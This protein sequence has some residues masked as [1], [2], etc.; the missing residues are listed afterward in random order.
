MSNKRREWLNRWTALRDKA[1]KE[2]VLTEEEA[3]ELKK[4]DKDF[5]RGFIRFEVM[6]ISIL[7]IGVL[8]GWWAE[9]VFQIVATI[10]VILSAPGPSLKYKVI[11]D[12]P[13]LAEEGDRY[14]VI[15]MRGNWTDKRR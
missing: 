7:C 14:C 4:M 13:E 6:L 8:A 15:S 5:E 3:K 10:C 11:K 9:I 2:K 12:E 1:R